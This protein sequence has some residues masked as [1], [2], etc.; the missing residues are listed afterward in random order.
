MAKAMNHRERVMAAVSHQ[1]PDTSVSRSP[2]SK[3]LRR[4]V[5]GEREPLLDFKTDF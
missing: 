1:Q 2:V 5:F 3:A 4:F